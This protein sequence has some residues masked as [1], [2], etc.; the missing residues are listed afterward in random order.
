VKQSVRLRSHFIK[1]IFVVSIFLLKPTIILSQQ[2]NFKTFSVKE[3]LTQSEV[4]ILFQDSLNYIWAGT[5]GGLSRF[6][7]KFFKT[8]TQEDGLPSDK[9]SSI[10]NKDGGGLWIGTK[11]GLA[12]LENGK[13]TAFRNELL[14]GLNILSINEIRDTLWI[15]TREKG[16]FQYANDQVWPVPFKTYDNHKN[17]SSIKVAKNGD[18]LVSVI[19]GKA[20]RYRGGKFSQLNTDFHSVYEIYEDDKGPIW[21]STYQGIAKISKDS[22]TYYRF[23][24]LLNKKF[25]WVN[26]IKRGPNNMLWIATEEG[27]IARFDGENFQFFDLSNGFCGNTVKDILVD[28]EE[29]IWFATAGNGLCRWSNSPFTLYS[30][31]LEDTKITYT[32]K[33]SSGNLWAASRSGEISK[34]QN[35]KFTAQNKLKPKPKEVVW[36]IEWL[37]KGNYYI[38]TNHHLIET[39]SDQ[40][41]LYTREVYPFEDAVFKD[42]NRSEELGLWVTGDHR[43]YRLFED[44]IQSF[45]GEEYYSNFQFTFIDKDGVVWAATGDNGLFLKDGNQFKK[46]NLI[47]ELTKA[48][49]TGMAQDP[50]DNIWISTYGSGLVSYNPNSNSYKIFT[51][52]DGLSTNNLVSL[53]IANKNELWLGTTAGASLLQLNNYLKDQVALFTNYDSASGFPSD[54]CTPGAIFSDEDQVWFG[55]IDGVVNYNPLKVKAKKLPQPYFTSLELLNTLNKKEKNIDISFSKASLSNINFPHDQNNFSVEFSAIHYSE[56]EKVQY[57]YK[58]VNREGGKW[59]PPFQNNKLFFTNLQPNKY[60]LFVQA[61]IVGQGWNPQPIKMNF[62]V[63]SPFWK[64]TGFIL[65]ITMLLI[66]II[67]FYI[68]IRQRKYRRQAAKLERIVAKRTK[69]IQ[70]QNSLLEKQNIEKETLIKEIHHRVK[71]NLQMT[72]SLL[73]LQSRKI[74]ETRVQEIFKEAQTRIKSMSFVHQKLYEAENLSEINF[75]SY[76]NELATDIQEGY[77]TPNENID[78]SINSEE[79]NLPVNVA[80]PL[81]LIVNELVVNAFKYAFS[82]RKQGTIY[83]DFRRASPTQVILIVRDNGSGLEDLNVVDRSS[84]LGFQLVNLF[85]KQ[86]EG[87]FKWNNEEGAFFQIRFPFV[88]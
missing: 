83:I 59:S 52:A 78:L 29:N 4:N 77:K 38:A 6:D 31:G 67:L 81:G 85:T 11:K 60:A 7:G 87:D 54:E 3:G 41:R 69:K 28:H 45:K 86:L 42:I 33:D 1:V 79:I 47:P 21:L 40:K 24:E 32:G 39:T 19:H 12:S 17:V 58:L 68:K 88:H 76:L 35:K 72:S 50:L 10:S 49:I 8:F 2:Y 36:D 82:Y 66:F 13:I 64:S 14:S 55:T 65:G 80:I 5:N 34:W 48:E 20:Y 57:R 61:G 75:S 46:S 23:T 18:V 16:L 62:K 73:S 37:D 9:I 43:I 26:S 56:P 30:K 25:N 44:S 22:T 27:G 74:T 71:N 84:G 70:K 51:K 63:E 15:G 53:T